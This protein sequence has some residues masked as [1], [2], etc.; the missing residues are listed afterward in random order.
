MIFISRLVHQQHW[1]AAHV[2][3]NGRDAAVIPKVGYR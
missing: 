2:V 1:L 3:Y